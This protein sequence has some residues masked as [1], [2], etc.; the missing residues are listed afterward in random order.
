MRSVQSNQGISWDLKGFVVPQYLSF[1]SG[2]WGKKY[3]SSLNI[4]IIPIPL[5][6]KVMILEPCRSSDFS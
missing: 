6:G 3:C 5:N 4:L 2:F 1:Q